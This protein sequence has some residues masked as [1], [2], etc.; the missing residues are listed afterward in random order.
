MRDT[1]RGCAEDAQ[2]KVQA[3]TAEVIGVARSLS[4]ISQPAR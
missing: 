1:R 2:S 3:H 4:M